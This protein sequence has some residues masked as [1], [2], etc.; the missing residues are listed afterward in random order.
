[1]T[2]GIVGEGYVSSPHLTPKYK[3]TLYGVAYLQALRMV[4]DRIHETGNIR[5][6]PKDFSVIHDRCTRLQTQQFFGT[7][8]GCACGQCAELKR[9]IIGKARL[10]ATVEIRKKLMFQ[11]GAGVSA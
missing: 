2:T 6:I 4:V 7:R 10:R 9:E 11:P 1:M 5:A 3:S 8:A